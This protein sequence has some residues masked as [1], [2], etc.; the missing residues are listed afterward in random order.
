MTVTATSTDP[1]AQPAMPPPASAAIID[2]PSTV[3][4]PIP[5]IESIPAVPPAVVVPEPTPA[6]VTPTPEVPP[7]APT[8][9]PDPPVVVPPEPEAA[10]PAV[11]DPDLE[12]DDVKG[13]ASAKGDTLTIPRKSFNGRLS[14][15]RAKGRKAAEEKI[16]APLLAAGFSSIDEAL[17]LANK[18]KQQQAKAKET[19]VTIPAPAPIPTTP[20]AA[21]PAASIVAPLT[22]PPAAAPEQPGRTLSAEER[23]SQRLARQQAAQA[24]AEQTAAAE[25]AAAE[26]AAAKAEVVASK[27]RTAIGYKLAAERPVD[28]EFA[29]ARYDAH[30]ATLD[31]AG[32]AAIQTTEGWNKWMVDFKKA[33]PFLFASPPPAQVPANTGLP[34][35]APT[36]PGP[37]QVAALGG[38][39]SKIDARAMTPAQLAALKAS[40]G[41][42]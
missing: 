1:P 8:P 35:V 4:A 15:E 32:R 9:P 12:E 10:A 21:D 24:K 23:R 26:V 39:G 29:L 40:R 13:G 27:A 3:A 18:H 19:P 25:R 37:G 30:F 16:L 42:R 2:P 36:I 7:P 38:D 11:P 14:R 28:I 20:P 22:P 31:E 17:D 6:P 41:L 5:P 33:N 34:T